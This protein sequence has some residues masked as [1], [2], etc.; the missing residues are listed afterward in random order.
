M[1]VN[2]LDADQTP[3]PKHPQGSA[4]GVAS[5]YLSF[6][7]GSP[8]GFC[9]G[10]RFRQP[11]TP[12]RVG[13]GE[14]NGSG[15]GEAEAHAH[16]RFRVNSTSDPEALA[17]TMPALANGIGLKRY[18]RR[19]R[20]GLRNRTPSPGPVLSMNLDPAWPRVRIYTGRRF[21]RFE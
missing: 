9:L 20:R 6:L 8:R 17:M 5:A 4:P 15:F 14:C 10:L 21:R 3:D 11:P 19:E 2:Q 1:L 13:P 7:L 12:W 16:R 18:F